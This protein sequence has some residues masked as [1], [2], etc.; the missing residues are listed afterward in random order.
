LGY[1]PLLVFRVASQHLAKS[2]IRD[3][4]RGA[5]DETA[6]VVEELADGLL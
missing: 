6:V 2:E 4:V 3:V 1:F 5:I